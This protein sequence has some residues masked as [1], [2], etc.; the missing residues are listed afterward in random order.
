MDVKTAFLNDELKEEVYVSQPDGFV[1]PDHPTH[2]YRLKKVFAT[3]LVG[4]LGGPKRAFDSRED[5]MLAVVKS[6]LEALHKQTKLYVLG[7][8]FQEEP[9]PKK[10]RVFDKF[11]VAILDDGDHHLIPFG[12]LE[13]PLTAFYRVD[14]AITLTTLTWYKASFPA[15]TDLMILH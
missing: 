14:A 15:N 1:D 6:R 8:C 10:V 5:D 7:A 12:P 13:E 3:K 11:G 4:P 9:I 2:V